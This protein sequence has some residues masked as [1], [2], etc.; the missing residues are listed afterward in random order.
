MNVLI[1]RPAWA[2]KTL[3]A[4]AAGKLQ[5]ANITAFQ[6]RQIRSLHVPALTAQ[7]DRVW[8]RA[9][10]DSEQERLAAMAAWQEKLT[11]ETLARA[12]RDNGRQVFK[13]LCASC[14]T[15][16]GEGGNIGPDLTGAA[17]DNLGYLLE[18]ILFPSAIV[19]EE[20]R[21]ATVT[22]KDGRVMAGMIRSRTPRLL[23]LQT[24]TGPPVSLPAGEIEKV[25]IA[26]ISL[27]PPGLISG[28]EETQA[29]DLLGYLMVK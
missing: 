1:S 13:S 24:M 25:E 22:L 3:D 2:A 23:K 8:G 5:R 14:H 16:N 20:F 7:L 4:L 19:P 12:D 18:N 27:M 21:L 11:P 28:L 26:D 15:L 6:A 29:R 10:D 9:R 17:R